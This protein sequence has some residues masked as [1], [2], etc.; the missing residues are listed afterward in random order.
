MPCSPA[1]H[2][3]CVLRERESE[4]WQKSCRLETKTTSWKSL[5]NSDLRKTATHSV[6]LSQWV[7]PDHSHVVMWSLLI[8]KYLLLLIMV[9]ISPVT[10]CQFTPPRVWSRVFIHMFDLDDFDFSEENQTRHFWGQNSQ[11]ANL[12]WWLFGPQAWSV[13][14]AR[15]HTD[16]YTDKY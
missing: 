12:C 3:L 15:T 6:G 9:G 7:T 11:T 14:H 5:K 4:L 8:K 1:T 13:T 16:T 2:Y 10:L